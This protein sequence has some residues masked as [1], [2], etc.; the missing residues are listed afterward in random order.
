M[1]IFSSIPWRR[2][3]S[4]PMTNQLRPPEQ[5]SSSWVL[6]KDWVLTSPLPPSRSWKGPC[7]PSSQFRV[8]LLWIKLMEA[9]KWLPF[10][11]FSHN[12]TFSLGNNMVSM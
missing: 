12:S 2:T 6:R 4:Y 10:Y 11:Y 5:H 8:H 9:L 1:Q 3:K 7:L